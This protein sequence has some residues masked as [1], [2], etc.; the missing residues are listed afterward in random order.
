[1]HDA[2]MAEFG[3]SLVDDSVAKAEAAADDIV[4]PGPDMVSGI[5]RDEIELKEF[6]SWRQC[7]G[8]TEA[9]VIIG[10]SSSH[11]DRPGPADQTEFSRGLIT[12]FST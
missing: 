10:E 6:E 3:G 1:M 12:G 2:V 4:T 7:T 8:T 11:M 9:M 5:T